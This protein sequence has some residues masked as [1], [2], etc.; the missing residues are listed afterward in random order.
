MTSAKV[1]SAKYR[2]ELN[3][4]RHQFFADEPAEI[5]GT[6]SAPSPD[7]LLE[8]ALASCSSITIK[9]YAE[10]KGWLLTEGEVTVTLARM[11]GKTTMNRE[12][13]LQGELSQEQKERLLQI[14]KLCP[15]S[16]T[17][18]GEI[19]ILSTLK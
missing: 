2:T 17:L 5:G 1:S 15:V 7:E 11:N 19:E 9:M 16:K 8:A 18:S 6:D 14:A 3:N 12:I 10:R 13:A 4:G